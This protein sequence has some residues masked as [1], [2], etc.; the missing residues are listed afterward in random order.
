MNWTQNLLDI[1]A[2]VAKRL[3]GM[4]LL[5]LSGACILGL[6][7]YLG[8]SWALAIFS[9]ALLL[10]CFLGACKLKFWSTAQGRSQPEAPE[11][12]NRFKTAMQGVSL[13]F[14]DSDRRTGVTYR[15]AFWF[16]L[17]D[18]PESHYGYQHED[19]YERV[20]PE[21][22]EQVMDTFARDLK[23]IGDFVELDYRIRKWDGRY[24]WVQ[25]RAR[26]LEVDQDGKPARIVGV[27]QDVTRRKQVEL[28]LEKARN[29]AVLANQS[30]DHFMAC[31]SHEIRTPLSAIIGMASLLAESQL[32]Q[33]DQEQI[34]II[35][36]SALSL[37]EM[38][39]SLLDFSRIQAGR[40]T[41]DVQEFAPR[42]LVEEVADLFKIQAMEKGLRIGR[43]VGAEV[44]EFI[45]GD[46]I[47]IRQLLSNLLSNAVKFSSKGSI[48][49]EARILHE[50]DLPAKAKGQ[51]NASSPFLQG[52]QHD[53]LFIGV[54]DEG[55]GIPRYAEADIFEPFSQVEGSLEQQKTGTGLGLAICAQI[56]RAMGGAI[57]VDS[58]FGQ[59]SHFQFVVRV[60]VACFLAEPSGASYENKTSL[61]RLL[62]VGYPHPEIADLQE[63]LEAI[64]LRLRAMSNYASVTDEAIM[65]NSF[66]LVV[67][68]ED[69]KGVHT[70]MRLLSR[71]PS[72][73]K[74]ERL[75]GIE[76]N[77]EKAM[78][79]EEAKLLGFEHVLPDLLTFVGKLK[80]K[81]A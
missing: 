42:P 36:R 30:R 40:I 78:R 35:H 3:P 10:G 74:P 79:P 9:I 72:N 59:G 50:V 47:R 31:I 60:G 55:M 37:L 8:F 24:V 41:L 12:E 48:E 61:Q 27:M 58:V 39:D 25:D 19:W 68:L 66:A 15:D 71:L 34:R 11:V 57:W 73:A 45:E 52:L 53:Y 13:G 5:W 49:V 62:I 38:V 56:V 75:I 26:V 16:E 4:V 63:Q 33:D 80:V 51:L 1:K 46:A 44:P 23:Q 7:A 21:E 6:A 32:P 20:A 64:G 14:W 43:R 81:E 18:I 22:R 76:S 2:V 65:R 17:L 69:G 77:G 54:R 67:S 70:L 29:A 28:E